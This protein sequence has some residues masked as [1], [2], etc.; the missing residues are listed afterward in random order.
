MSVWE[1]EAGCAVG[2]RACAAEELGR[3]RKGQSRPWEKTPRTHIPRNASR[4]GGH[5]HRFQIL[6]QHLA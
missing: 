5:A 4:S 2:G 3:L 6:L 1:C